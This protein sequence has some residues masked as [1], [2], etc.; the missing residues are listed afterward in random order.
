MFRQ[1]PAALFVEIQTAL[2]LY[3]LP[4]KESDNK[5]EIVEAIE[6]IFVSGTPR[7]WWTSLKYK[8]QFFLMVNDADPMQREAFMPVTDG[9]I[10]LIADDDTNEHKYVF[11]VTRQTLDAVILECRYFEYYVVPTDIS[12]LMMENDHGA[13]MRV[14]PVCSLPLPTLA[15]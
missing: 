15:E 4:D 3:G 12:W 7:A 2:R 9:Y 13:I 5:Q 11:Q 1:N 14:H 6:S 8:P 10:F